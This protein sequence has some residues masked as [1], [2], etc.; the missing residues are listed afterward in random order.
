M[1]CVFPDHLRKNNEM[2]IREL[3]QAPLPGRVSKTLLKGKGLQ[4]R[5]QEGEFH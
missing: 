4:A 1:Q 3:T 5:L 2:L